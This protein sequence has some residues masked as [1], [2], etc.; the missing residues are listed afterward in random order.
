MPTDVTIE[1]VGRIR[2][3]NASDHIGRLFIISVNGQAFITSPICF[4]NGQSVETC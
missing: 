2:C 1:R 3:W 4:D